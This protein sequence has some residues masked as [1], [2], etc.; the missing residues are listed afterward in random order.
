MDFKTLI[1]DIPDFPKPG[2][3]FRDIS[4]ILADPEAA[5]ELIN[6]FLDKWEGKI[7]AIVA[8][9]ARGFVL[10]GA[11]FRDLSVPLVLVRKKGKLPG[12]CTE[13]AYDLE[14]GSSVLEMQKGSLKPG[15]R[16]LIVDDLLATG[17]TA[18]AACKLVLMQGAVVAGCAFV[19]EL[20]GLG[21]R[22]KLAGYEVQSL[23]TY[24]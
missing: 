18:E 4:P 16:V 23:V 3:I 20:A 17:G 8:I 10:G 21:G 14:Y 19:I 6:A 11:L 9:D 1:S 12:A 13:C 7:D 24:E 2:I 22:E 15:A 5:E